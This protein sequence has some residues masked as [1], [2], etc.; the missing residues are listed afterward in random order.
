MTEHLKEI[1]EI[2]RL[3]LGI[4]ILIE[5]LAK[6]KEYKQIKD[7]LFDLIEGVDNNTIKQKKEDFEKFFE[8]KGGSDEKVESE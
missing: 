2:S 5:E 3:R 6:Y 7:Y 8:L 1:K 4:I